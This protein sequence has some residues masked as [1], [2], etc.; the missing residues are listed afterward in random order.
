M[1]L[2]PLLGITLRVNGGLT[3]YTKLELHFNYKIVTK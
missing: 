2:T 1:K 3:F